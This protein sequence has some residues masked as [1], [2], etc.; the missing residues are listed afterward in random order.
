MISIIAI[1]TSATSTW[2]ARVFNTDPYPPKYDFK[3]HRQGLKIPMWKKY[4]CKISLLACQL[5]CT[6]ST[7]TWFFKITYAMPSITES[8]K[9]SCYDWL[10]CDK[11]K[12]HRTQ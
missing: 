10:N 12:L 9:I 1:V 6:T 7:G 2:T 3:R 8:D 11:P 5:E 4:V